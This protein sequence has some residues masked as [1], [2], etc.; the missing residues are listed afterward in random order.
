MKTLGRNQIK[1]LLLGASALALVASEASAG[2]YIQTLGLSQ[3]TSSLAGA[4]TAKTQDF[5]AF[6][7][8]PA[9]AADFVTPVIGLTAKIV[10]TT[11]LEVDDG[12]G[13]SGVSKTL[14][15]EDFAL[16]PAAGLY[17]PMIPGSVVAGFGIGAPFALGADFKDQPFGQIA[18]NQDSSDIEL[19]YVEASPTVAVKLTDRINVGGSVNIG[20]AKHL[21]LVAPFDNV[22]GVGNAIPDPSGLGISGQIT[23]QSDDDLPLPVAPWEFSTDP[24]AVTFTLGTQIRLTDTLRFGVT[25]REETPNEFEGELKLPMQVSPAIT[26]ALATGNPANAALTGPLTVCTGSAAE[27]VCDLNFGVERF[28]VDME[29]PRHIQFGFAWQVFPNWELSFD[30]QW[31]NWADA[32]GFGSPLAVQFVSTQSVNP[33]T[34]GVPNALGIPAGVPGALNGVTTTSQVGIGAITNFA[35]A[36]A[37]LN[38][39]PALIDPTQQACAQGVNQIVLNYQAD[40]AWSFMVGSE[41][42]VNETWTILTGYQYDQ[43]F[44]PNSHLDLNS[45]DTDKHYFTGGVEYSMFSPYGL[46]KLNLGGQLVWYEENTIQ[47]GQSD[48]AGGL[49]QNAS[50]SGPLHNI[51]GQVNP[52]SNAVTPANAIGFG[53]NDSA[54]TIGDGF[55]WTVGLGATL[56]FGATEAAPLK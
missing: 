20:L 34:N 54:I 56:H 50:L 37:T 11:N 40:D 23:A 45:Y 38:L 7:T 42:T 14:T 18:S 49:G 53:T 27:A 41:Y 44:M 33:A 12:T 28:K 6:Y 8:N 3:R 52:G 4:V 43:A 26:A 48:T 31:T 1:T 29:L 24:T 25:Y 46:L 39:A 13:N 22:W 51:P 21:K 32:T 55:I 19:L 15:G 17:L 47:A 36:A 10:D 9:G 30:A 16:A 5:D 35:C 2:G